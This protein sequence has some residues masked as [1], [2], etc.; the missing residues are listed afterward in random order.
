MHPLEISVNHPLAMNVDQPLSD[1]C[2]LEFLLPS[3]EP[4][5]EDFEREAYKPK[6]VCIWMC[7]DEFTDVSIHHPLRCHREPILRHRYP[8]QR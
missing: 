4:R 2:Q 1:T 3:V 5:W 6:P 7:L 8:H